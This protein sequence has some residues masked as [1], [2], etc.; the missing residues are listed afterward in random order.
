[1]PLEAT[2][3]ARRVHDHLIERAFPMV[4]IGVSENFMY[5]VSKSCK[6]RLKHEWG[7]DF[8]NPNWED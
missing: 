8:D 7:I 1:M 6:A 5:T 2:H 4:E 3:T